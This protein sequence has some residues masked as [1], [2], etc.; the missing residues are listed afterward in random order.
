MKLDVKLVNRGTEGELILSGRLDS[1]NADDVTKVFEQVA[2]RF[3]TVNLNLRD[4]KFI[5]SAGLRS[6][7]ILYMKMRNKDGSLVVTNLAPYVAEVL[8]MTGFSEMLDIQ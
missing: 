1:T 2:D 5:S 4:L 7:K 3:E 6:L 8:E